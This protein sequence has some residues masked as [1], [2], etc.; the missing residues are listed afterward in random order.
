[1]I[2]NQDP[3]IAA[4][5]L[6]QEAQKAAKLMTFTGSSLYD[7]PKYKL[8]EFP[9]FFSSGSISIDATKEYSPKKMIL[10]EKAI[11]KLLK[12]ITKL[13]KKLKK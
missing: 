9:A 2:I 4:K 12:S 3:F 5:K 11:K 8:P 10:L 1:M 7:P 6:S 13:T